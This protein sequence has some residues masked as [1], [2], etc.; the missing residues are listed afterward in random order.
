MANKTINEVV[1]QMFHK[2]SDPKNFATVAEAAASAAGGTVRAITSTGSEGRSYS[3]G[4]TKVL[5]DGVGRLFW[6]VMPDNS[7][8][9]ALHND[10]KTLQV[11]SKSAYEYL[12]GLSRCSSVDETV[13]FINKFHQQAGIPQKYGV[14][15]TT[16]S[17]GIPNRAWAALRG[18]LNAWAKASGGILMIP[19]HA[20]VAAQYGGGRG[21]ASS[22]VA[23]GDAE[24]VTVE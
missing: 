16:L 1:V 18:K 17:S 2:V 3:F 19:I 24:A 10:L 23:S 7:Y 11:G 22:A 12:L 21:R 20:S 9:R 4:G 5:T 8:K 14:T 15:P 13:L 6:L